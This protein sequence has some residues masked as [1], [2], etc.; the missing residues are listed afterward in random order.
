MRD[1][2]FYLHHLQYCG[3]VGAQSDCV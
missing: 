1:R 2:L 3:F